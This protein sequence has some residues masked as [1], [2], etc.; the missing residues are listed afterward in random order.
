MLP[1]TDINPAPAA[2]RRGEV[3]LLRLGRLAYPAALRLMER[4][5]AA[6]RRDEVGDLLLLVE[7]PP[8]ITLGQ[9]GG[10]E[11]VVASPLTLRQQG[12]SVEQ[13]SRGG[14]ATYHGPGQLVAYPILKLPASG[15][16]RYVYRLEETVIRLLAG[17]GLSAGRLRQHPGVWLGDDKIAAVGV[18]VQDG[19]T[20]HG[21]A[22]NID[23]ALAH[24]DHIVPCG[25]ADRGVTSMR[26]ALGRPLDF[27]RVAAE[28]SRVFGHLFRVQVQSGLQNAPWLIAPAPQGA[29]VEQIELWL[30]TAH[31]HT[32]CE[33]AACPNLGECWARGTATFMILG[34]ICTR[35]CR[36]CAV[37]VGR[38]RAVDPGEP[39]RLAE[40]A[41]RMGLRHVVVTSVARDDLPDG[42][43][44]HFAAVIRAIRARCTGAA[45]EVLTPDFDGQLA[46]L[47]TVFS[48]R[49]DVFNHNMETVPRLFAEVQPRKDYRRALAVLAQA[50]RAGLVTKSGLMLGLGETRAE[51]LAVMRDLR[52]AGCQLLTLGQYLQ[53]TPRHMPI[54]EY[55]HPTE[56]GWYQEMGAKLGF[57][58]VMAGPLVRSSYH[59]AELGHTPAVTL[60]RTA[61]I[62]LSLSACAV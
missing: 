3:S 18:A 30:D 6:R 35:H 19:V 37:T 39:A 4:L 52:Q 54:A 56:F 12:I 53:P 22:L 21:V 36:F 38:P 42:G 41:A 47:H 50:R 16:H 8:V 61:P 25:L 9:G 59:A 55:I 48:A 7:H 2:T 20:T 58:T 27:E 49:P 43:A 62:S 31:L 1:L 5:A 51:V 33:E 46:A 44:A 23:P 24:F 34:D 60:P 15:L 57:Q 13:T 10:M 17:Y 28:F 40:T 32:V 29:G 45:V 14:R 11:D 26:R